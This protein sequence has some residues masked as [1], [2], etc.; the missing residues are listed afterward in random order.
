MVH[1]TL[2]DQ[3]AQLSSSEYWKYKTSHE[4]VTPQVKTIGLAGGL[5]WPYKGLLPAAL[6]S[7]LNIRLLHTC[8]AAIKIANTPDIN[9]RV[10]LKHLVHSAGILL[11]SH[12]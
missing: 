11:F 8:S 10:S 5:L 12:F 4:Q 7:A 2:H 1:I 6:A 9:F 3:E